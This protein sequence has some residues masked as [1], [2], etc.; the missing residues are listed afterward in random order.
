MVEVV[1]IPAAFLERRVAELSLAFES[2][3]VLFAEP[4]KERVEVLIDSLATTPLDVF[5]AK[6]DSELSFRLFVERT[7]FSA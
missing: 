5:V 1:L 4:C 6:F 7:L 3:L 2:G